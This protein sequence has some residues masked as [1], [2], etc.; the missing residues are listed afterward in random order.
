[1]TETLE[2]ARAAERQGAAL[3]EKIALHLAGLCAPDGDLSIE[4]MDQHQIVLFDFA[5]L[6]AQMAAADQLLSLAAR[7]VQASKSDCSCLQ[8]LAALYVAETLRDLRNTMSYRGAGFGLSKNDLKS[9]LERSDVAD[10]LEAM[11]RP[12]AYCEFAGRIDNPDTIV[13]VDDLNEEQRALQTSLRRFAM[14]KIAPLAEDIHREDMLIPD[15]MIQDVA[16]LGCF[17]VSI[18]IRYGGLQDEE[19]PDHVAMVLMSEELARASFGT[20]G[21]LAT[22]PELLAKALLKGGTEKQKNKWLPLIASGKR[23]VAVAVTEPDYGSDVAN[24]RTVARP[25]E[26]GWRL[27]GTKTWCTFAGRADVLMVLART[28]P[29]REK[30][31]RGLSL[32]IVE[33]PP[34]YGRSFSVRQDGGQISGRAIAT[35]GY[36]GLHSFEVVFE[37]YFVSEEH[38]IGSEAGLGRGFYLQMHGFGASRLQTAGRALGLMMAAFVAGWSYARQRDVF[39]RPLIDF[40]LTQVKMA[41]MAMLIEAGRRLTYH[42]AREMDLGGGEVQAAMAK[43]LTARA[44]EWITREAQ[45]L[46]GGMGYAE[47]FPISRHFVDARLLAIFEGTEEVLALRIIA[48]A[49]LERA[50]GKSSRGQDVVI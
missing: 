3:M 1:M 10:F 31:H 33:K 45:Q 19:H 7:S 2:L 50:A 41:R 11:L 28:D 48:R 15:Q 26:G 36:R 12:E 8:D 29:D 40:P 46:H 4:L 25:V 27:S 38:L 17:G 22:R 42:A 6:A 43:L 39:G 16:Q 9:H 49:L 20:A 34:E 21:S 23:L 30:A 24:L 14:D 5:G 18:P 35:L 47:E 44:A 37:D 13:E 32:F